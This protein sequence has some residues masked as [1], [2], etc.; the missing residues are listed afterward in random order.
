MRGLI[1]LTFLLAVVVSGPAQEKTVT[2][3]KPKKNTRNI[4]TGEIKLE[5]LHLEALIE[6]PSVSILPKRVEPDLDKVEFISRNFDRELKMIP[7][8]LFDMQ[9]EK[10][11]FQKIHNMQ[12][13]LKKKRN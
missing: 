11:K 8:E 13:L 4:Q 6:K 10:K 7:A 12:A 1:I 3:E 2:A 5:D 9:L